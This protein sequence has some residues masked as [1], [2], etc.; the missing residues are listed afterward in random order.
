M[1]FLLRLMFWV[2]LVVMLLPTDEHQQAK[3]YETASATVE[4]VVTFCDRNPKACAAGAELWA[5]FTKKA[6]FG[7]RVAVELISTGGRKPETAIPASDT[8]PDNH[9]AAP[10]TRPRPSPRGTLTREDLSPAWRGQAP[11]N[12]A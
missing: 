2:G 4:R 9:P 8:R 5:T 7:A 10:E 6:E 12:G 1:F 3:L 11:R